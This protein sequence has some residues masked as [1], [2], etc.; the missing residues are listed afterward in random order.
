MK[1][2]KRK[3]GEPYDPPFPSPVESDGPSVPPPR[4]A[5][6]EAVLRLGSSGQTG[7]ANIQPTG[8][9]T[10]YN[11]CYRNAALSLLMNIPSFVG[12]L[13]HF[14][15]RSRDDGDNVLFELGEMATAYWSDITNEERREKL[16]EAMDGL[17]QHLLYLNYDD[18]PCT[19][20]WGPFLDSDQREMQQDAGD[21]LENLLNNG[22][23]E[24]EYR[25]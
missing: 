7:F 6:P 2:T 16:S 4:A 18:R 23:A 21:F 20:G 10:E 12:Y 5:P 22:D 19:T 15:V 9:P 14:S 8:F 3:K 17:W 25:Q 24:C 1:S 13:D 11:M